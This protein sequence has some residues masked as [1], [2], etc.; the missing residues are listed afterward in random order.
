MRSPADSRPGPSFELTEEQQALRELAHEFAEQ[1]IRPKAAEYDE[2]STHAADVIARAHEV[3]LM[4]LHVPEEFGGPELG[5]LDECVVGEELC[6]GCAGI[7]TS[8]V[9]NN[10][11]A[12]PVIIAGS[13]EQKRR[14]LPPLVAEP[15]LWAF[16]LTEPGAGSDVAAIQTTAVRHGDEYVLNGSKMF[17]TNAGHAA[18][19]ID[20]A[21]PSCSHSSSATCGANGDRILRKSSNQARGTPSA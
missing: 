11:G 16:A 8:V 5:I 19:W 1:E 20:P 13:E 15:I 2:R 7:G 14:F 10:L 12:A 21:W 9:A 3:G 6:W 18:F 17:I 4:N